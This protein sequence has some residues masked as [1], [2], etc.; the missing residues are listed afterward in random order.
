MWAGR[1]MD[2]WTD[3]T[4]LSAIFQNFANTPRKRMDWIHLAHDK[5]KLWT[6]MKMITN[7]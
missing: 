1:Q 4:K 5:D 2:R 3:M 7:F 6:L